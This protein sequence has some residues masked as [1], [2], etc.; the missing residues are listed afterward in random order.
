MRY[1]DVLTCPFCVAA[2]VGRITI[3][4][5]RC[6]VPNPVSIDGLDH[7][8]DVDGVR[9]VGT[10]PGLCAYDDTISFIDA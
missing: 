2:D 8:V 10:V 6:V 5:G 3:R 4:C 1:L 7:V 9:L